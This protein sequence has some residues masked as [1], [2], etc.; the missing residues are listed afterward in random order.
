[1]ATQYTAGL[2][3]G[4]VLTAATMNSIGAAWESYTPT[5]TQSVTVTK[6]VNY[7]KYCQ[8]NKLIVVDVHMTCT[9]AGTAGNAVL[10]GLPITA[11]SVTG[12]NIGA[13]WLYDASTN[14]L[15]NCAS[16]LNNSTTAKF[17]YQ[18]GSEWGISP[19]LALAN[20][21]QISFQF[22]YEAA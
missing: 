20:T 4:Q 7:A 22:C 19:N 1:M 15:Y 16:I 6:T 21:D 9:G 18:T 13:L 2:S 11:A 12:R 8:I 14:T 10:V 5:L 17:L 3:A